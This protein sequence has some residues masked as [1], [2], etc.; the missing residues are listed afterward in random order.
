MYKMTG[1]L[2]ME[3]YKIDFES[4]QWQAPADAAEILEEMLAMHMDE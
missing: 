2:K 3:H 1:V 4:M